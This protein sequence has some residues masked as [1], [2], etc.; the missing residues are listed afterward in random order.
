M[1]FSK[2]SRPD[3]GWDA[4]NLE[5]DELVKNGQV[6]LRNSLPAILIAV[7][8]I[9][10][11]KFAY[12]IVVS[13]LALVLYLAPNRLVAVLLDVASWGGWLVSLAVTLVGYALYR[14]IQLQAFEG[15]AFV[16]GAV[17]ALKLG[18]EVLVKVVGT[19]ALFGVSLMAGLIV[20]VVGMIIPLFF[21]CQA[22]YLAATTELSPMECMRRSYEL[23][24]AYAMPVVIAL[25][26]SLLSVGVLTGCGVAVF[27][28][29]GAAV[30]AGFPPAGILIGSFSADLFGALGMFV[31]L[32]ASGAVFVTVQSMERGV[33]LS[34][35]EL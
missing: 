7:A 6:V 12:D 20:C 13:G 9:W 29:I 31:M 8:I 22:P 5:L 35:A 26:V 27:G 32:V 3:E 4:G 16:S 21:F 2:W 19:A 30:A 15:K 34:N 17:E 14:P 24:K 1:D 28:A 33:P 23:N 10:G 18:R 25:A 11:V